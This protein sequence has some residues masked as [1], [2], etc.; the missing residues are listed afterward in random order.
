MIVC[1][2]EKPLLNYTSGKCE[3][4]PN[5]FVWISSQKTCRSNVTAQCPTSEK[6][7]YNP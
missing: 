6:P 4:C 5:G 3:G 2:N 7:F 1:T